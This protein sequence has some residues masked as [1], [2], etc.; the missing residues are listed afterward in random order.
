MHSLR[1]RRG[2]RRAIPIALVVL[3]GTGLALTRSLPATATASGAQST[4]VNAA[5]KAAAAAPIL[6]GP[7]PPAGERAATAYTNTGVLL[8]QHVLL[9]PE[10]SVCDTKANPY[11]EPTGTSKTTDGSCVGKIDGTPLAV[12]DLLEDTTTNFKTTADPTTKADSIVVGVR[13]GPCAV[14]ATPC[15]DLIDVR[16]AESHTTATCTPAGAT[17][18]ASILFLSIAGNTVLDL[19]T[20]P[21]GMGPDNQVID[22][23]LAQ[24]VLNYHATSGRNAVAAPVVVSIPHSSP[25]AQ[26]LEGTIYI[27]YTQSELKPSDCV[28]STPTPG[29]T[30][31][32]TATPTATPTPTPTPTATPTATPTPTPTEPACKGHNNEPR[33]PEE[34]GEPTENSN[35][36]SHESDQAECNE[37]S[38]EKSPPPSKNAGFFEAGGPGQEI[39]ILLLVVTLIA[40]PIAVRRRLRSLSLKR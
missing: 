26:L 28:S 25:L 37:E 22:L 10:T 3:S 34:Q 38:S 16:A 4:T 17:A 5:N 31:T 32:P 21:K 24:I 39:G 11:V 23:M 36:E 9:P 18:N 20:N 6:P 8:G 35:E 30:P 2:R 27:S 12:V 19:S 40:A 13:V 7:T 14:T 29:P 1:F 33:E 15:V